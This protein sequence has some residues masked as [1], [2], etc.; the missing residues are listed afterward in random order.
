MIAGRAP[1][2][3]ASRSPSSC[4][5]R[6]AGRYIANASTTYDAIIK[7]LEVGVWQ[8]HPPV[9]MACTIRAGRAAI[10]T[11]G[12]HIL[13]QLHTVE[14]TLT[15]KYQSIFSDKEII[16]TMH[17]GAC[18]SRNVVHDGSAQQPG[19]TGVCKSNRTT[20]GCVH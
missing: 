11:C 7:I 20:S 2:A 9:N 17:I 12:D 6:L 8:Y 13:K 19:S 18:R 16:C 1:H 4:N 3:L 14:S 5:A 15:R 10:I